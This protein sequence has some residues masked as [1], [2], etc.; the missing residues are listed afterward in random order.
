MH[1]TGRLI[2]VK[3]EADSND[4][5][6]HPHDNNSRPYLCTVC[7]K[8]YTTKYELNRHMIDTNVLNVESVFKTT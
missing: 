8:R 2:E 5:T 3:T 1:N 4:I 7:D 6:E